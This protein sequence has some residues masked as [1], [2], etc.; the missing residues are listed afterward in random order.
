[1][2]VLKNTDAVLDVTKLKNNTL[3]QMLNFPYGQYDITYENIELMK[4]GVINPKDFYSHVKSVEDIQEVLRLV[5][6]KEAIK[7][8]VYKRQL[9]DIA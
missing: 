8:D 5:E 7:V 3:L 1:M 4:K 6:T 9:S 2:G